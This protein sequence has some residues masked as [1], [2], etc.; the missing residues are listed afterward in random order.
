MATTSRPGAGDRVP[1]GGAP[2]APEPRGPRPLLPRVLALGA[3]GIVV[4][5]AAYLLFSGGNSARYQLVFANGSGLVRGDQVQVGG[6]PVGSVKSIELTPDRRHARVTVEVES[7]LLPLH[8][9][10]TAQIRVPSLTSVAE[11]YI[12]L[13]PGPNNMPELPP[14]STLSTTATQTPVRLDELFNTLNPPTRRGLQEFIEGSATQYQ[15][16]GRE[17]NAA[18][19]YFSPALHATGRI[20]QELLRDEP[21]FVSFLVESAKALS[22]IGAHSEQLG[23]LVRNGATTFGAIASHQ[24]SFEAGLKALPEALRAGNGAFTELP[25]TVSALRRLVRVSKPNTK[26]L[27]LFFERLHGLLEEGIAPTRQLSAAISKPGANNDLT[28]LARALP[29][30]AAS[31]KTSSPDNV[32]ALRQSVPIT[33]FFGPY[34][35]DLVGLFNTFGQVTAYRDANGQFARVTPDFANFALRGEKLIPVAP[36][37]GLEGLKTGQTLRC[38]GAATQPAEDGSSPFIDEGLLGCNPGQTP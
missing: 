13:T 1:G 12:A 36:E 27:A 38:P 18:T 28:D 26:T 23:S 25:A 2:A 4:L 5:I 17:I 16:V 35:P 7:S 10:T 33:N 37:Q 15:H 31:L 9:G 30:L 20:F 8:Q 34:A 32:K 3:L 29:G 6:V 11:N 22:T 24:A 19:P 21:T 14:G